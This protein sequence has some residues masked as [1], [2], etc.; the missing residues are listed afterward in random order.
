MCVR[1]MSYPFFALLSFFSSLPSLSLS[2]SI[3][4][5]SLARRQLADRI[6]LPKTCLL[7]CHSLF[8]IS[9]HFRRTL[10]CALVGFTTLDFSS[11]GSDRESG[12]WR[13]SSY[14][15]RHRGDRLSLAG[16]LNNCLDYERA[17]NSLKD[18]DNDVDEGLLCTTASSL[19]LT[20]SALLELTTRG[21]FRNL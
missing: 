9:S 17:P 20:V 3:C 8:W 15:W 4:H 5:G 2:L 19:A 13:H 18:F 16:C 1:Y 12:L 7:V 10:S 11:R 14:L 6:R 21:G